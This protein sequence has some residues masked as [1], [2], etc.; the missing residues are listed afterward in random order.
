MSPF[1]TWSNEVGAIVWKGERKKTTREQIQRKEEKK[2]MTREKKQTFNKTHYHMETDRCYAVG[3]EHMGIQ[4]S[5]EEEK[6][7]TLCV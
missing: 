3:T 4:L 1:D 6:K 2:N 5:S 7:T